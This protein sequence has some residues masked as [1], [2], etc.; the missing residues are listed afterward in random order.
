MSRNATKTT[1]IIATATI[2]TIGT[3]VTANKR[4]GSW[5][6]ELS[7]IGFATHEMRFVLENIVIVFLV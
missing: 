3:T 7:R 6:N 1:T 4:S 5:E 2:I